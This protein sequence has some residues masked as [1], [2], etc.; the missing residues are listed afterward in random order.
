MKLLVL[1]GLIIAVE[2][3]GHTRRATCSGTD[4]DSDGK[5]EWKSR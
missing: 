2:T 1:I 3:I 5:T 4:I